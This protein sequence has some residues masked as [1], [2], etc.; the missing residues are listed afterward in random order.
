LAKQRT[1][2]IDK[3]TTGKGEL[4]GFIGVM[5]PSTKFNK[6][7]VYSTNILIDKAEGEK[8]AAKIKEVRTQQYKT[9]GKGSAVQDMLKC[10]PFVEIEKNDEGEIIKE[11]PDKDGRYIVKASAKAFIENGKPRVKIPVFDSKQNPVGDIKIGEGTTA[12]LAL[13]IEGYTVASKTG[14]SVKLKALQIIDLVEYGTGNAES[15]GFGEEEG[16]ESSGDVAEEVKES[17]D[18]TDEESDF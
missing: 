17:T 9:Y 8:L 13:S 18:G 16:F 2:V 7:G 3:H 1:S 12:K 4:V 14:V 10:I 11:T 15:Y 6:D 5:T